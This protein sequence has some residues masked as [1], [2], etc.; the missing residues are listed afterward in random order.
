M[1]AFRDPGIK[2]TD[3]AQ[4]KDYKLKHYNYRAQ[5]EFP[6]NFPPQAVL[7]AF[8]E[9]R[10]DRSMEPFEWAPP[11][12]GSVVSLMAGSTGLSEMQIREVLMPV[13]A[14]M[15]ESLASK[16]TLVEMFFHP[17]NESEAVAVYKS[18]RL[19]SCIE[20]IRKNHQRQPSNR[21]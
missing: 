3:T 21:R 16:Q 9:P 12:V 20:K 13:V 18:D 5:W 1:S 19:K 10:V 14:R 6:D 8:A 17:I 7:K 2:E 4:I 11:D 15:N